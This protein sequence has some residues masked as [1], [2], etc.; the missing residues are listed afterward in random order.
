M[1]AQRRA[2]PISNQD[3]ITF[4]T[5]SH[6]RHILVTITFQRL[7]VTLIPSSQTYNYFTIIGMNGIKHMIFTI[8]PFISSISPFFNHKTKMACSEIA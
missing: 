4:S 5:L 6:Y 2:Q 3:R 7:N 8:T 1:K